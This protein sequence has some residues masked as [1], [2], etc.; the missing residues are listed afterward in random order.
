MS[1]WDYS[2]DWGRETP[3]DNWSWD[4]GAS[5]DGGWDYSNDWGRETPYDNWSSGSGATDGGWLSS[6]LG[7]LGSV[8]SFLGKNAGWLGPAVSGLTGLGAGA[9]GA[10]A[11]R[12]AAGAQSDALNRALELQTAQWLQQQANQ[13]PWLAAGQQALPQLQQ[14]AGQGQP[15]LGQLAP[16][17]GADYA[18]PG[19][20]PGWNPAVFQGPA[21]LDAAA[22]R[23]TPGQGP[24]AGDY[25]YTPGAV[26]TVRGAELL[27]NDPGVQFRQ[28]E[29]R[30]AL[31]A[32]A[33]ARGGLLSG[34]TLAA[35]Q[36]QGQDLASQEYGN[37]WQRAAQQAQ[38]REQWAQT[39][40]QLGFGQAQAEAA[41][42]EQ[43]AQQAGAQNWQ[44]ALQGQQT[45]FQ[46]GL[47]GRQQTVGEFQNWF[48]TWYNRGLQQ[49]QLQ[50]ARDWQEREAANQRLM[51]LYN[52]QR[53][54]LGTQWNQLAGL[55]GIGQTAVGQLGTGGQ[56]QANAMAN[57]LQT[58]GA[59]QAQGQ[60]SQGNA[61]TNAL[62]NV[63]NAAQ[64]AFGN[65][66]FQNQ[67][68]S[69]LA[70]LNR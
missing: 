21:P 57:L 54:G 22:Y 33:A 37:A 47:Q 12:D 62:S 4:A 5:P 42:R 65:M 8:G 35:L 70:N 14:L 18:M 10:Q 13:A 7:T 20:M 40:S 34:S 24:R 53:Q 27:A 11:S 48:D 46:Q 26:P 55:A 1:E 67:L 49:H 15:T 39:A 66:N 41:F 52:A 58:L 36:R 31:E 16:I 2:N 44:Q 60:L 32:S 63:G 6:V 64:G 45:A 38:M 25:R 59:G 3:Y 61:W 9:L 28:E 50:Y 68:T 69:L 56:N 17:R 30:K 29:A 51:D 19:V 43:L 23:Y